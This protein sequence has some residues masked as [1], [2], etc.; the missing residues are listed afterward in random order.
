MEIELVGQAKRVFDGD[1][2]PGS[3]WDEL[4]VDTWATVE[5]I[6]RERLP[7]DRGGRQSGFVFQFVRDSAS[8]NRTVKFT[9]SGRYAAIHGEMIAAGF[10][11]YHRILLLPEE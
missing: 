3:G 11:R 1:E 8:P 6:R 7:P 10:V 2:E 4:W 5:A 9:S